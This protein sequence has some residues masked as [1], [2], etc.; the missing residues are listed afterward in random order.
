MA[1]SQRARSDLRGCI[2][3]VT[4][5][6]EVIE[7]LDY[8][9]DNKASISA[10]LAAQVGGVA[11]ATV[12][13]SDEDAVSANVVNV[14]I[15]LVDENGDDVAEIC[16]VQVLL[17][18]DAAGAALGVTGGFD[19]IASGT[20]GTMTSVVTGKVLLAVSEADGD[21]D[22]DFTDTGTTLCY[23]AV[24]LPNGKM[25]FGDQAIDLNAA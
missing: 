16:R 18:V 10:V 17:F 23:I 4:G 13:V 14:A 5:Q 1:I 8:V 7:E 3:G 15:Q 11:G 20:D 22:I 2:P 24:V 25:V 6:N 21:I 9:S 19:T 12:T